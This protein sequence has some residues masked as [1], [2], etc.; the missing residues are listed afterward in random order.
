MEQIKIYKCP[1]L[2]CVTQP[3]GEIALSH[4]S[5]N[6]LVVTL[7]EKRRRQLI[8]FLASQLGHGGIKKLSEITGLSRKTIRRGK[9]EIQ[10]NSIVTDSRVRAS[11]GGRHKVEKKKKTC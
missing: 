5:I 8:G 6:R 3:D 11:G 10:E 2:A 7:D 4:T 1:C 9:R